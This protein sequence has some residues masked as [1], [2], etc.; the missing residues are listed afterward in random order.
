ML[1]YRRRIYDMKKILLEYANIIG[2]TVTGLIFGLS[3]F[4][5]IINFYHMQELSETISVETYNNDNRQLIE[6]KINTIKNNISVY[7]QNS[8]TG[9]LN[10][11]GLNTS[12]IKIQECVNIVESDEMMNYFSKSNIDIRDVYNF[13]GDFRNNVLNDCLVMQIKSMFNTDTIATLPNYNIIKPYVD[14]NVNSLVQSVGYIQSNIENSDHYYYSTDVNKS[15]F[16]DLTND[17]YFEIVNKYQQT[18][19]LLVE[20]SNWYRTVVVGG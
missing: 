18:L 7:S 20:V 6:Q 9:N 15:N 4:L 3:F 17:S 11:Y 2:Y 1:K 16:F 12:Q 13:T 14:L 5:L 10:I 19:D 8:Y